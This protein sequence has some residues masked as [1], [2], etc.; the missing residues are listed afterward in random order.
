MNKFVNIVV[1]QVN[2]DIN[3]ANISQ[4]LLN[5]RAIFLSDSYHFGKSP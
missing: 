4:G 2:I 1:I 5:T 3:R